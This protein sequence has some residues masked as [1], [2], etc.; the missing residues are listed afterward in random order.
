MPRME[1]GLNWGVVGP[2]RGR[3]F[4]LEVAFY[5]DEVQFQPAVERSYIVFLLV[6]KSFES[7]L[8]L[9]NNIRE[10]ES[11]MIVGLAS[12]SGSKY[13]IEG[14]EFS[15]DLQLVIMV[16]ADILPH[17]SHSASTR[18]KDSTS[19]NDHRLLQQTIF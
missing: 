6:Y 9:L 11:A 1:K 16:Y 2:R 3:D 14:F 8:P 10:L 13:D 5:G 19:A 12:F 17:L 15:S 7:V 18:R 4:L